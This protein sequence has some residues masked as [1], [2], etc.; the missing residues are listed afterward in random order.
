MT[1]ILLVLGMTFITSCEKD[2]PEPNGTSAVK[3]DHTGTATM[4][5]L[6][7]SIPEGTL[8]HCNPDKRDIHASPRF[9]M[10][11]NDTTITFYMYNNVLYNYE[12][13]TP[14]GANGISFKMW[15]GEEYKAYHGR[16]EGYGVK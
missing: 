4:T 10:P 11:A 2:D 1:M 15:A 3:T 12:N 13:V 14:G 8:I 5:F 7:G 9:Y 6:T 16:I